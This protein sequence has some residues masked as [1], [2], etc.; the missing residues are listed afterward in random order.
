[1]SL[2][3]DGLR[4]RKTI[5][6]CFLLFDMDALFKLSWLPVRILKD[7]SLQLLLPFFGKGISHLPG[8]LTYLRSKWAN[9]LG[10]NFARNI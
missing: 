10:I 7:L 3:N 6:R 2:G 1:M 5:L 4:Y 8:L 9:R